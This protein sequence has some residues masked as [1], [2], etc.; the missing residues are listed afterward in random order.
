MNASSSFHKKKNNNNIRLNFLN[1]F[2]S[3]LWTK[4]IT[5]HCISSLPL[6]L[7]GYFLSFKMIFLLRQF[8]FIF[9]GIFYIN[10]RVANE[11]K[12]SPLLLFPKSRQ[13]KS[14]QKRM[15]NLVVEVCNMDLI[16][17]KYSYNN[18][19][20]SLHQSES[21]NIFPRSMSITVKYFFS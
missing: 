19:F 7:S 3:L 8:F 21:S 15:A 1:Q 13:K 11:K 14:I 5:K 9:M 2:F 20:Q 12:K 10:G 18:H 6:P 16:S 4:V 17:S